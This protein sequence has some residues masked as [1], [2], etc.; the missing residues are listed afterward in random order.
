MHQRRIRWGVLGYA[1]IASESVIPALRRAGNAE[2]RA[3][4]SRDPA[5]RE[6]CRVR[7]AVPELP[8]RY[9]ALL[10]D[11]AIDAL[12]IPLPNSL[13]QEW[14]LR[15]LAAGKHV[16]CEKPL[17]LTG[18]EARTMRAAAGRHGV[19]LMEAFM[20]R[21]TERTRRV[22]E[23]VRSG[24]LG[25][26]REVGSTFRFFLDRPTSI[27][28][29][30]GLG[31]GSLYDV[32]CYPVNFIGLVADAS[33]GTGP[34]TAVPVAATAVAEWSG[35]VDVAFA[36]ALRYASGLLGVVHSGFNAHRRVHAEIIGTKGVLKIRTRTSTILAR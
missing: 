21:Y 8:D 24:Q 36:G 19:L 31:G 3:V 25:E 1:R 23:I 28:W 17:G 34:G 22:L 7:Y 12:Y 26:I 30:P 35:G 27:K 9:E 6:A 32:G 2:L 14:T 18:A 13:H 5:R 11:P 20:Y 4:A 10:A 16:L 15:A 29:Q 33:A